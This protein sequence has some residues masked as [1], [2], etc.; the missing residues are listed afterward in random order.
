MNWSVLLYQHIINNYKKKKVKSL[1]EKTAELA[2][3]KGKQFTN[4]TKL[5]VT[6][7]AF[8][9]IRPH[10]DHWILISHSQPLSNNNLIMFGF[11]RFIIP[12][13]YSK[14]KKNNLNWFRKEWLSFVKRDVI[15]FHSPFFQVKHNTLYVMRS[16]D[17]T[18]LSWRQ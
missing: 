17:R 2:M 13:N 16:L 4:I 6:L 18:S 8:L 7:Q 11:I 10:L 5:C 15:P 14:K 3:L 9:T 1:Q 12:R